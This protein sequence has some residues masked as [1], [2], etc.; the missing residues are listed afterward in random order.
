MNYAQLLIAEPDMLT[1]EDLQRIL[2]VGRNEAYRLVRQGHIDSVRLGASGRTYRIPKA[3]L[4]AFL[5][6]GGSQG[7]DA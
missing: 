3:A 6:D 7:D 1:V 5:E 2:R 4:L